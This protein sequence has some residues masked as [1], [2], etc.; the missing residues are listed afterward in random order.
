MPPITAVVFDLDGT[1][2]ESKIDYEKM[3][4]R[5]KD[6]LVANGMEEPLEDR[7]KV[8]QVIRG[9]AATLR[10]YGLPED[11]LIDTM[12][13]MEHVMNGIE[14]E[15]LETLELKPQARE[16]LDMLNKLETKLGIATR[17]HREYTVRGLER[18]DLLGYFQ[19]IVAR[20]DALYPKPDPKHLLHVIELLGAKPEETLFVGDTTTDLTTAAAANVEFL[21]YWRDEAWAKRLVDGGCQ[22]IVKDLREVPRIVAERT[23]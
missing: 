13:A 5:I 12:A 10:D 11:R 18:F 2:L 8:Y 20:D 6:L 21:G 22:R 16:A 14:L 1:L 15:A 23:K 9:G 3:G 4:Q 19:H 7:R 17:S